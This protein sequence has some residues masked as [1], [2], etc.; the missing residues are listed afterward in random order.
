MGD[1]YEH[2]GRVVPP[3]KL[4]E[5]GPGRWIEPSPVRCPNGHRFQPG[6]FTVGWAPCK[7]STRIGHRT[8]TCE[9]GGVVY[10][11]PLD[12]DCRCGR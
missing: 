1:Y 10:T 9:C 8:H 5:I 12:D 4:I 6:T 11:P 3:G 2:D 7:T